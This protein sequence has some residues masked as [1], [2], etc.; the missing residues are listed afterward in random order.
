MNEHKQNIY[1]VQA[2]DSYGERIKSAYLPYAA[3]VLVSNAMQ[4]ERIRNSYAFQEFIFF[5]EKPEDVVKR[6]CNPRIVGFSNYLWNTEYNKALA[7]E[8]KKSFPQCFVVFGG[9]NITPNQDFLKN[10]EYIDFLIFGEGERPFRE[11]LLALLD[12]EADF[13]SIPDIA[14]RTPTGGI[15]TTFGAPPEELT[16][17]SPYLT[18]LFDSLVSSHPEM[19]FSA[20]LETSRGCPYKCAYCDWGSLKSKVRKYPTQQV[21]REIEWFSEHKIEY[22][23]GADANFGIF[24]RDREIIEHFVKMKRERGYPQKIR[25]NYS[26][27]NYENVFEITR[28]LDETG[29]SK[30]GA[31]LSFQSLS[32]DV[33]KIIRRNN[34]NTDGFKKLLNR[35]NSHG[36]R[37]Y[38]ELILGLP[39]ETYDSFCEGI[40]KLL[41][42]GQHDG[43]EY[44][45]CVLLPNSELG[46][47]EAIEKYCIRVARC[48][49]VQ[50]H[51]SERTPVTE[52]YSNIVVGTSTMCTQDW[53]RSNQFIALVQAMHCNGM[54]RL[55]AIYL[56]IQRSISYEDFYNSF[57]SFYLNNSTKFSVISNALEFLGEHNRKIAEEQV[58]EELLVQQVNHTNWLPDE[59]IF[60]SYICQAD[61]FYKEADAFL[62]TFNIE[63]ELYS[64]LLTYQKEIMRL[65]FV[66]D[67]EIQLE[68][69]LAAFFSD[70]YLDKKPHL[71]RRKNLLKMGAP[72]VYESWD[73]FSREVVWYERFGG[74]S[75]Y[76]I[77]STTYT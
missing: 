69:D 58:M 6:M 63:E 77:I 17:P 48:A 24:K 41:R 14:Y 19:R 75:M 74:V 76:D 43:I 70:F 65:P 40:G 12:D 37:T 16:T 2:S 52:E 34:I 3:G 35:Y 50:P 8:I 27:L 64:D 28:I 68:Y 21:L 42:A 46:S 73:E 13:S 71:V 51:V 67:K 47:K 60:L 23:W 33:L 26:K 61:E 49:T 15:I 7:L 62:R 11:L 66:L 54:L 39:G 72:K 4:N 55:F 38:S 30:Y 29:S 9:H 56:Y 18:G 20:I 22:I 32:D 45:R 1:M 25:V 31:T 44:Y 59:Y 5:R 10:Y 57:L 53:I 36:I